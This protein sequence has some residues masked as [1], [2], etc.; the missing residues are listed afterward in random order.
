MTNLELLTNSVKAKPS[1]SNITSAK[2]HSTSESRKEEEEEKIS[3]SNTGILHI[4][5]NAGRNAISSHRYIIVCKEL[6]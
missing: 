6:E 2:S 5:L 4:H 3:T 1:A